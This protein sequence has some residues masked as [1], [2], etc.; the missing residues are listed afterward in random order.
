[1][2]SGKWEVREEN[3][4]EK[5]EVRSEKWE[6]ENEKGGSEKCLKCKTNIN[7]ELFI[8]NFSFYSYFYRWK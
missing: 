7:F 2:R 3:E 5:L 4:D 1:V 8:S 6:I